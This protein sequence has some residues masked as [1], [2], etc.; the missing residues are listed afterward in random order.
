MSLGRNGVTSGQNPISMSH[1]KDLA[2]TCGMTFL[3][4][5]DQYILRSH[6]EGEE[7]KCASLSRNPRPPTVTTVNLFYNINLQP[8]I[9]PPIASS[10]KKQCNGPPRHALPHLV[11]KHQRPYRSSASY[12]IMRNRKKAE[13]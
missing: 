8:K 9:V 13:F 6:G 10:H 11:L 4:N 5:S 12:F 2:M 1:L 7:E 3:L